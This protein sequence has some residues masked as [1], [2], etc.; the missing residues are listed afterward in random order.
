[1][2]QVSSWA[3][4][5]FWIDAM[6]NGLYLPETDFFPGIVNSLLQKENLVSSKILDYCCGNGRFGELAK[7]MGA[8]VVGIDNS[9]KLLATASEIMP[10]ARSIATDLPFHSNKFDYVLS[11]NALHVIEDFRRAIAEV[12]RVLAPSGR[13]LLS[14]VSPYAEKWDID[15]GLC[16]KDYSNYW[17]QETRPWVFNL[18]NS[19]HHIEYYFHRPWETYSSALSN[20]FELA[21]PIMPNLLTEQCQQGKYASLEYLIVSAEKRIL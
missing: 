13:L 16:Y 6:Q 18:T 12:H 5:N 3:G 4:E 21:A 2:K 17:K 11:F 8:S 10:V 20:W 9:P 1:M 14:I 19:S 7:E 15:S